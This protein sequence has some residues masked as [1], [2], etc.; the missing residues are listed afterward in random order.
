MIKKILLFIFVILLV[1][2][3]FF[4]IGQP[5]EAENIVW[6]VNFSQKQSRDLGLDWQENYLALLDDLGVRQVK[7]AAHWDLLEPKEG[8]YNFADLDWQ[9]EKATERGASVLLVVGLKTPRWPECHSPDWAK[10]LKMVDQQQKILGM[11]SAVVSRYNNSPA[12]WAW[13]VENEPFFPFG[14]CT[15]TDKDFLQAEISLVKSLDEF[16]RPVLI[17]DSGEGSFWLEAARFGDIVGTTLYRKVWVHQ[18]KFYL[19][20]YFPPVFYARKAQII[21]QFFGKEVIGVEL[22]AEPWGPNLLAY[23]PREEQVKTMNPKQLAQNIE[24]AKKTGFGKCYLWGAEWWY[25]LKEKQGE[26]EIWQMVKEL[27]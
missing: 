4:F 15:W 23:S 17:S 20:Y 11:L 12:V 13:Q 19:N 6:G 21:K 2:V 9:I 3:V 1:L 16:N 22:Q 10:D 25:W 5:K 27:F 24:F 8:Q 14:E 26:P 18:F 7:L